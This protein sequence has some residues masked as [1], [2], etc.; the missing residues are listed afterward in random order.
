[1][2]LRSSSRL[3]EA[4]RSAP[5]PA[6]GST[7][8]EERAIALALKA[9]GRRELTATELERRLE[10]RGFDADVIE[11]V[12]ARLV[13]AG[14]I[15]DAS[16]ARLFTEDKRA[17]EGWGS[18]R[19]RA[20]LDERGVPSR[21][22]DAALS[23]VTHDGEIERAVELLARR[24]EPVDGEAARGRAYGFLVRRGYPSEVAYD[25]IR[26]AGPAVA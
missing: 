7:Q 14:G 26:R 11:T 23:D 4:A 5:E 24:G 6:R 9:L 8:P 20:A 15:D 3:P 17:L 19:V 10:A 16:Y 22:I 18:E 1:M 12:V 2:T 21:L 25:A 13:E